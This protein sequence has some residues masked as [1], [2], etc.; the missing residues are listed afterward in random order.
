M[1]HAAHA[2][3]ADRAAPAA[4]MPPPDADDRRLLAALGE[5]LSYPGER[6]AR[7]I[8]TVECLQ[9]FRGLAAATWS[10]ADLEEAYTSTFDL[11]PACAPYLG[12]H[13]LGEDTGRRGPFLARLLDLYARDGFTP[14]EE[15]ADHVAEVLRFLAVASPGAERDDLVRDGLLP[16]LGKMLD[17][18]DDEANPYREVLSSVRRA[19]APAVDPV[20]ARGRV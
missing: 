10:T 1:A 2:G 19:I 13:L 8:D 14:R 7:A 18:L 6:T 12:H 9:A 17:A 15:L 16:A 5:L 3:Q 4:L 11:Q 20:D